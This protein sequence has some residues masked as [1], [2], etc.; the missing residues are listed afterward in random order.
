MSWLANYLSN[1]AMRLLGV[2]S[3]I[4]FILVTVAA[5]LLGLVGW[6][7]AR[8]KER[9]PGV[10]NWHLLL[11][12]IGG[13][14]LFLSLVMGAAAWSIFQNQGLATVAPEVADGDSLRWFSNLEM[15]GGPQLGR[16]VFLS[17]FVERTALKKK[18]R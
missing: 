16:P 13:T 11:T 15:E 7:R 10:Q 3:T 2:T 6:H 18:S 14:W 1:L 4:L 12:G 5:G 8:I 9:K 17:R